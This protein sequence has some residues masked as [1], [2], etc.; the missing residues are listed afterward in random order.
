MRYYTAKY[1]FI[2]GA[3]QERARFAIDDEGRWA[4]SDGDVLDEAFVDLGDVAIFPGLVNA[5]SH[6]FQRA[7]RGRTERRLHT[8]DD[9]WSWRDAMY[10]AALKLDADDFEAI[11]R[12]AFLEM[13]RAG[14]TTVGEFHYLH[15]RPDGSRYA[16][17]NELAHR[18]VRAARS[19]GLRINLLNVAYHAGGFSKP[20]TDS[21]RRFVCERDEYFER[22]DALAS[23]YDGDPDVAVGYAPHSLRAVPADWFA[24]MFESDRAIHI[25]VAEQVPELDACREY[26]GTTPVD[27]L[28]QQNLL[29]PRVTLVHATHITDDEISQIASNGATICVCPTTERNLGDGV[30]RTA[31]CVE[32]E[33][34]LCL[35]TDS[36][37]EIDL[38]EDVRELEYLERLSTRQRNV[39]AHVTSTERTARS[40]VPA[41]SRNGRNAL[42]IGGGTD[43][44]GFADFCALDL[45]HPSIE[46]AD[47]ETL[48]DHV[49]FCAR[50]DAVCGVWV[51]GEPIVS[52]GRH[53]DER[54]IAEEFRAAMKRLWQ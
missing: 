21:Q 13:A 18:V 27:W 20:A 6:A 17:P 30:F 14:I 42:Q 15:H 28:A 1:V 19:V 9:V 48:L 16:D 22:T 32:H 44:G 40:L 5:H 53:A 10:R 36:H 54:Q 2:D 34:P 50:P 11:S 25:H 35:G 46:G 4:R 23:R 24:P 37:V 29:D 45:S 49:I 7:I 43:V 8:T 38:F 47:A 26:F 51:S 31:R 39:L 52:D 33:I 41:L 3:F 12:Y